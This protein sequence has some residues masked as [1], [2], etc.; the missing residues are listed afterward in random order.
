M[1]YKGNL[2]EL[3]LSKKIH[4]SYAVAGEKSSLN[5]ELN[6]SIVQREYTLTSASIGG[7]LIREEKVIPVTV[8][9]GNHEE[10]IE[11]KLKRK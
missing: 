3:A 6:E 9:W 7:L 5:Q 11:L 1:H 4:I 8:K 2:K 10:I